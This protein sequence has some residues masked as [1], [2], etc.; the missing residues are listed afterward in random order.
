VNFII[1]FASEAKQSRNRGSGLA[2]LDCRGALILSSSQDAPRSDE[3][4]FPG[5]R[6]H[7][8]LTHVNDTAPVNA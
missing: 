6:I 7:L 2:F 4:R 8:P 3:I 5:E 1:V